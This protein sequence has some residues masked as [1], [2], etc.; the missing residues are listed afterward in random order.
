MRDRP[1]Q[2]VMAYFVGVFAYCL[3]LLT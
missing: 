1:N 3:I 2:V